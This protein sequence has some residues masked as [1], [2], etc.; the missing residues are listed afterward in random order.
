MMIER[1]WIQMGMPVTVC[2]CDEAA[3]EED[4]A[5]VASLLEDVNQRFSPYLEPSEV[6]RLNAGVIGR[7]QVSADFET[8]LNLCEQAK[9]ETDGYFDVM[10]NGRIDPSGLVKGW[11]IARA[12]A[13]LTARGW[14]NYFVDAGGDVQT[15]GL[16]GD[17]QPW[18]VGI[19][20]PFQRDEQVK[21]LAISGLGVATSG[22]AIRGQHI[23]NPM[24][25][26]PLVS[27]VVSLTVIGPT[28][29]EADKM[30]TAAFAMGREGISFIAARPELEGYAITADGMG[31]ST[32]G[33]HHYV[34]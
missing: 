30:A 32:E 14:R 24:Q 6:S 21:V 34:R 11:A 12:S 16:N 8:I 2:I 15:A 17:H 22:T 19:R 5:A 1:T 18:R 26:S 3:G 9:T 25:A 27:D 23:Y 33:F 4:V 31:I 28:I 20:N 7:H 29:F 13:L 10:R